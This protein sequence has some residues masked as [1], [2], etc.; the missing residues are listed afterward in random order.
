MTDRCVTNKQIITLEMAAWIKRNQRKKHNTFWK[1]LLLIILFLIAIGMILTRCYP[2]IFKINHLSYFASEKKFISNPTEAESLYYQIM[3]GLNL[4]RIEIKRQPLD[5][6][7]KKRTYPCFKGLWPKGL[8]FVWFTLKLQ[9]ERCNFD[10]LTYEA[11]EV[12]KGNGLVSWLIE[13]SGRDTIAELNLV[14]SQNVIAGVSSISLMFKDFANFRQKEALNLIWLDIPFGFT[15]TPDQVPG[16]KL[17]KALKSSKGQCLL[18][19]PTDRENWMT[20]LHSHKLSKTI[21][22]EDFNYENI[23]AIVQVFPVLD[24]IILYPD[25][26]IDRELVNLLISAAQT[27]RLTYIYNNSSSSYADSLAYA[28]GLKI[29]RMTEVI[30]CYQIGS[31]ELRNNILHQTNYLAKSNKGLYFIRSCTENIDIIASLLPLFKNLNIKIVPPLRHAE[32]IEK[33]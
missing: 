6:Q 26:N 22:N 25:T 7:G 14:S 15:L 29:R 24:A 17:T 30:D 12:N 18:E 28:K 31:D 4:D 2:D 20:I 8:P 33:L 10:N 11:I 27:L 9:N 1:K 32:V 19:L 21:K 23:L 3:A 16:R 13:S 5:Y